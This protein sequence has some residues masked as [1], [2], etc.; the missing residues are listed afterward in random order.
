MDPET[1]NSLTGRI[2]KREDDGGIMPPHAP[3][4]DHPQRSKHEAGK[5]YLRVAVWIGK[6]PVTSLA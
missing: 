1:C 4:P 3:C 2:T 5:E 6:T